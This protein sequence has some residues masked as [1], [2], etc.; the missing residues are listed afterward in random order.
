[1]FT[2][3]TFAM[4]L[5]AKPNRGLPTPPNR[6][7]KKNAIGGRCIF[8]FRLQTGVRDLA[9]AAALRICARRRRS[10]TRKFILLAAVSFLSAPLGA[11]AAIITLGSTTDGITLT[12]T[13]TLV[14]ASIAGGT[15]SGT[16]L[17]G[18][19]VGT[20][21]LGAVSLTA[22]PNGAILA[23]QYPVT[24]QSPASELFTYSDTAGH[25]LTGDI[26]WSFIQD[27]TPNPKFFGSMTVLTSSG[28][29]GFISTWSPGSVDQINFTTTFLPG[30]ETLDALVAAHGAATVGIS[31]GEIETVPGPIAGAGLPGLV[32]ACGGLL[33][34]WRRKRKAQ[35]AA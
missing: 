7:V 32:A 35:A 8:W 4:F 12:G 9:F 22:G 20:Y 19:T 16:L 23:E 31:A 30:G 2:A 26:A 25:A 5:S 15:G 1:L 28:S 18:S 21:T 14:D 34:W 24:V 13:G 29:P 27:N 3:I 6:T 10:M 11:Q 33:A 17:N